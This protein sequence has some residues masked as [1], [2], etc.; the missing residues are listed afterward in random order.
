MSLHTWLTWTV[1]TW[2]NWVSTLSPPL[3]N[4]FV[5]HKCSHP[6]H[7]TLGP[8]HQFLWHQPLCPLSSWALVPHLLLHCL[9]NWM[10]EWMD[11][12]DGLDGW[13]G[14]MDRRMDGW[15]EG[16]MDGWMD[17]HIYVHTYIYMHT[18]KDK[19]TDT[20]TH[21]AHTYTPCTH[22]HTM[23]AHNRK[24]G[25]KKRGRRKTLRKDW[26]ITSGLAVR[27]LTNNY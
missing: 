26:R 9:V 5:M 22:I 4:E 6:P 18:N 27:P 17:M 15:M 13:I 2:T 3:V 11:W 7:Q 23:H 19:N 10:D 14:W 16:G 12:M 1:R 20:H 24:E 8:W 25:R 21:H